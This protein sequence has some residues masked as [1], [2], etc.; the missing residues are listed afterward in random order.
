MFKFR[1]P[2]ELTCVA[3]GSGHFF[4][5]AGAMVAYKGT[6]KAEKVMIDTNENRGLLQSV[7]NLAARKLSGENLPLMKVNGQGEYYMANLAQHTTVIT[8]QT[9]QYV[10]VESENLLAFT[11]N[12][13][14]GVRM[15]GVGVLSQKGLFTSKLEAK[16]NGAQVVIL[17]EGNPI[18]LETPC[19]VDPDAVICWTGLDPQFQMDVS[20]KTFIGQSSGESYFMQFHSAGE[21]VIVQ[22]SERTGSSSATRQ[23]N[24]GLSIRD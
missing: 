18:V 17:S 19:V 1:V 16:E 14:Y 4:C 7:M 20:W 9:G 12:C 24:A 21:I 13:D 6:F 2:Q 15:I 11:P 8:L 22:P 5:K 10:S 23:T 3:E